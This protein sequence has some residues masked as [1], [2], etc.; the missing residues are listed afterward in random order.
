MGILLLATTF[1]VTSNAN[2]P[3]AFAQTGCVGTL[4]LTIGKFLGKQS[5]IHSSSYWR[6]RFS[7]VGRYKHPQHR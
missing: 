7:G 4:L 2:G 1:L 5:T 6:I 3:A